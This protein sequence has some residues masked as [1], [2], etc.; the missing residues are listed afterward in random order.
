[1][2]KTRQAGTAFIFLDWYISAITRKP[3]AE[4]ARGGSSPAAEQPGQDR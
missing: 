2:V 3:Q 4:I 1:L